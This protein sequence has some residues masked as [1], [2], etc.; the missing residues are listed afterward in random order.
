M[1]GAF[2][3]QKV[4][5]EGIIGRKIDLVALGSVKP[6]AQ[7]SINHDKVLIYERT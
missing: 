6:F 1:F 3:A 4:H 2:L 5:L 7:D